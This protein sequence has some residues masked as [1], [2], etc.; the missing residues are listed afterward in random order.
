VDR[1]LSDSIDL[2]DLRSRALAT[3]N[4]N[5]LPANR[6]DVG[7]KINQLRISGPVDRRCGQPDLQRVAMNANDL[8]I[9]SARLHAN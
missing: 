5:R 9:R 7:E 8:I 2:D 3:D 4:S 1:T 6:E